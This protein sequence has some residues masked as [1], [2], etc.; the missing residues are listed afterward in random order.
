MALAHP[1]L[2]HAARDTIASD[3]FI[4]SLND[5]DFSL[6]VRQRNPGTLDEALRI[7]LQL[8]AWQQDAERLRLAESGRQRLK[9]VRDAVV[10]A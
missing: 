9:H 6:K 2:P 3:Y 10:E 7:S 1:D 8:E 5:A 4:D